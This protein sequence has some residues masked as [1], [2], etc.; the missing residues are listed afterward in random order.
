MVSIIVSKKSLLERIGQ[1]VSEEKVL[2]ALPQIKAGVEAIE[3]DE[4][5]LEI[6]G[7]RPDLLSVQGVARAARGFLG[8]EKGLPQ[9]KLQK[10]K[11]SAWNVSVDKSVEKVRP[12][13]VCALIEGVKI[14]EQGFK[15]L[16]QT[17]EKLTLTHGR[18]RRK[19]AIG[20]H[21][22]API[23]F[24]LV[25][26]AISKDSP[27]SFVPLNKTQK[28]TV[29]QVMREHEKGM[30]YAFT[31]TAFSHYPVI[32]DSNGEIISFPPIIN[33][34]KTT[35]TTKTTSLFVDVTGTD[36]E[37]C[38]A[39]LNIICQD[40]ADDGAKVYAI[41]TGSRVTPEITP[42]KMLLDSEKASKLIGLE[43]KE[44]EIIDCLER[45]RIDAKPSKGKIEALIPRYRTDFLH[46]ADLV[47]EIAIGYGYNRFI[48]K[49]PSVFTIGRLSGETLL[50]EKVCS[51]L[52]GAGFVEQWTYVLTSSEKH[53]FGEIVKIKNPV[54]SDYDA[55][56]SS[57]RA[58]LLETIARNT[59]V[60]YPQKVFEVGE[61]VVKED[62]H[63]LR[64]LTQKRVGAISA[65]THASFSEIASVMDLALKTAGV[66]YALKKIE[67]NG[68]I[69][70]R[71]A[72]VW[73][74]G[75]EIGV[76]GEIH[77]EVLEKLQVQVPVALFEIVLH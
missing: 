76:V 44:K 37:A 71:C 6:K 29:S 7:D 16:I 33:S 31:L 49:A 72:G 12:V 25:Y 10:P 27:I 35:V 23:K 8:V 46:Q 48:P 32:F 15:D 4:L 66:K 41:P 75:K 58:S 30:E 68:F 59:H 69:S 60:P 55:L 56:R 34:A 47:E 39:A 52:V 70:G 57:L 5:A 26:K 40:Y 42:E 43:L 36:F 50:E 77:P 13:I 61:V 3:G 63:H 73:S 45:Q 20:V 22:A 9:M 65:H 18:R 2:D 53:P 74:D 1:R 14:D 64:S 24:P 38:N 67:K 11:S 28:M 51:T 54:S 21:D 17:Q 19:V 62:K